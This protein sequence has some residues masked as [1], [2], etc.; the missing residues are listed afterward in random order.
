MREDSHDSESSD[1]T[2]KLKNASQFYHMK[3]TSYGKESLWESD[4][5][6]LKCV[7]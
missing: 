7:L 3:M 6:D 1:R 4:Y 5:G 2:I